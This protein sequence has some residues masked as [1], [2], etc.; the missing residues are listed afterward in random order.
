M[1]R[2]P[3]AS[4]PIS[5]HD[6]WMGTRQPMYTEVSIFFFDLPGIWQKKFDQKFWLCVPRYYTYTA[7]RSKFPWMN[8]SKLLFC[9]H[10]PRKIMTHF[11]ITRHIKTAR[12]WD[13]R[14]PGKGIQYG[15][16]RYFNRRILHFGLDRTAVHWFYP[17][18]R[19]ALTQMQVGIP[20]LNFG[21]I[22]SRILFYY[23]ITNWQV[24]AGELNMFVHRKYTSNNEIIIYKSV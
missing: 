19:L 23:Q 20:M 24:L 13:S 3:I 22:Y 8:R 21:R 12:I 1:N 17:K 14:L 4:C 7:V 15:L 2:N 5:T 10:V 18:E 6:I 9:H 11:V 16:F